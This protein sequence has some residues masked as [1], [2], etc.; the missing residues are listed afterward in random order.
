MGSSFILHRTAV[1]RLLLMGSLPVLQ[2]AGG[3]AP[4]KQ[5]QLRGSD[6]SGNWEILNNLWGAHACKWPIYPC[7]VLQHSCARPPYSV[8]AALHASFIPDTVS[9]VAQAQ[10]GKLDPS[11]RHRERPNLLRHASNSSSFMRLQKRPPTRSS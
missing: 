4:V 1:N 11:P 10:P 6:S 7:S 5:V 9:A 2:K 3:P 8:R